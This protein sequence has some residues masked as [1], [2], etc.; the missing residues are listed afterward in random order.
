MSLDRHLGQTSE[1]PQRY[2]PELL[3]AVPRQQG[4]D[5][6]EWDGPLPF[7]GVDV[8]NAH[9]LSW[10]DP[11]GKPVVATAEL[12]VPATSPNLV[13]S[14]SLKLY[15][16][17]F[18]GMNHDSEEE[19]RECV[20]RDLTDLLG[21]APEVRLF[22]APKTARN[23][24]SR[25]PA[26]RSDSGLEG[27]CLDALEIDVS[28]YSVD[29]EL[30]REATAGNPEV[31]ETLY[32]H[33]LKSNCPV[34]SQPD[35]ATVFLRYQGPSIDRRQLLK[36]IISYRNHD[37][38]HEHCVERIFLDVLQ[39]CAPKHLSVWAR[40][41]RRGGIDINPFRSNFE[42]LTENRPVWRQ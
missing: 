24:G 20:R 17:S 37:G 34:T 22:A 27:E 15:L 7:S 40:Y 6:F 23:H 18:H 4:R 12:W 8:W 10:L 30:L 21:E 9:E 11:R 26:E 39:R 16:G 5:T 1:Y 25:D 31:S 42:R 41:T 29:S 13:E 33:L 14:K 32:S 38:F 35:W 3:V 19:V 2:A 28:T 36:Y